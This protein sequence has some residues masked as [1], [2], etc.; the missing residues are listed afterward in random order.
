MRLQVYV[1]AL[2]LLATSVVGCREESKLSAIDPVAEPDRLQPSTPVLR[3][4]P[5]TRIGDRPPAG[6]SNLVLKTR[7]R[8]TSGDLAKV[9]ASLLK[10][11][12][13]FSTT[14]VVNV[15][16]DPVRPGRFRLAAFAA[17]MG[18]PV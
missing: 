11:I 15:E 1:V 5:G 14:V 16:P 12:P 2:G 7:P 4:E 17:G 18:M 9:S 13:K 10:A 8:V 3:L 6:W